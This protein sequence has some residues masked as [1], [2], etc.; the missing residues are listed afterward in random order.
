MYPREF[1][2]TLW[3][4]DIR[5]EVFVAMP[6]H[7][8]F[9]PVWESVIEPAVNDDVPGSIRARRVDATIISGSIV[10]DILDG[11][12]HAKIVL[13]DISIAAEGKWKGQRNGNVMYEVGL[14]HAVRHPSELCMIRSDSSEIN[15][16]VAHINVHR[17]EKNNLSTSR[18]QLAKLICGLLDGIELEKSL[19]VAKAI[20]SLDA[21]AVM[22]LKEFA[23]HGPFL[24]P[25]PGTMGQELLAISKRAALAR[26]QQLGIVR[27]T[28][29]VPDSQIA[30][31]IT[32]FGQAVA[33][34]LGI[35]ASA[36]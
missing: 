19:R 25:N 4:S 27:A 36:A 29:W 3:R 24:G 2:D 1:F 20:D 22:Y 5:D 13:A 16:D 31:M 21:D 11:I 10:T 34:N 23:V 12:A 17:Y 6:F 30:F 15:F 28:Q 18:A 33:K 32:P 26:L 8:E 35:N 9:Q 14:A 7:S